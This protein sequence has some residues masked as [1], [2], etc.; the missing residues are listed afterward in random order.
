[1]SAHDSQKTRV[2]VSLRESGDKRAASDVACLVVIYGPDLGRRVT[3]SG[4]AFEVGR[5]SK[6]D[7][8][9]DQESV[10]RHHARIT[11]E[12][13]LHY[14]EDLQSTNGT[15]VND[16]SV[17]KGALRD[18][19]QLQI[20]RT[21]LK[22]M[23]GDNVE[24]HYHEEIYRLMTI[25]GLTQVHNRRYFDEALE[26]EFTR[27]KRYAR[28]LALI[29][30]DIDH[31]KKINDTWG[32]LAGD[33]LLRQVVSAIKPKL[34]AQDVL[35]R[36]GG[37]EFAILSPEIDLEGARLV[38]EKVRAIVEQTAMRFESVAI[39]CTI[40]L[41]VALVRDDDDAASKLHRRADE[42]LYAAKEAGRNRVMAG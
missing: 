23:T 1:V 8:T 41:G 6:S 15:F 4:Q 42:L 39:P 2:S 36:T 18:G 11:Y 37:E 24:A 14:V 25:D 34:R 17:R 30:I 26:R 16:T 9:I 19:D 3:L 7:L 38:A 31:F 33:S 35:A 13:A 21:I 29:A 20:G 22:Y 5:S 12:N 32:H 10:S 27:S 40:S 28:Q